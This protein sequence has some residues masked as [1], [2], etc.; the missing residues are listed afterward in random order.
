M[1]LGLAITCLAT[2]EWLR[3]VWFTY[4]KRNESIM[5]K[6]LKSFDFAPFHKNTKYPWH[7]WTDGKIWRA[8]KNADFK[9][10]PI[11]FVQSLKNRAK[12]L[13]LNLNFAVVES[14]VVFQFVKPKANASSTR[15]GSR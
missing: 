3:L 6:Q 14:D 5:A 1:A 7:E 13:D 15:K 8:S 12:L 4:H 2:S 11:S 10:A 9:I